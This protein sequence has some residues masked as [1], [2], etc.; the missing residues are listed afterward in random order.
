MNNQILTTCHVSKNASRA[1]ASQQ[2]ATMRC[3]HALRAKCRLWLGLFLLAVMLPDALH[4]DELD[5]LRLAW[6]DILVGVQY[7][8]AD[9]DVKARLSSIAN[10][11]NASW[12]SMNQSADRTNLWSDAASKTISAHLT[13]CYG[14]LRAMA[15]AYA[16]PGCSLYT[17]ASLLAA[18]TSG[19]DW[20][21]S[22]RYNTAIAQYD[23]WWDWEIGVPLHLTDIGVLLYG[24]LTGTQRTQYMAAVNFHTPDPDMTQANL[25]WKARV[26]AVRGCIVRDTT[27][28]A[29]ARDAFSSVFPFV[30]TSDGFYKDGSFIQHTYH[31]YA[32]GYGTSLLANMIPMMTWLANSTWKIT[33]P[34]QTNLVQW[35]YTAF[36][37]LIYRGAMWDCVRGR[38]ISRSGS[39]PQ[40]TGHSVLQNALLLSTIVPEADR[41]RLR[42]M[43]KYW[44]QSDP[45]RSF[46]GT[47]P[48]PL[49]AEAKAL[50]ADTTTL[51]RGELIGHYHFGEMDRVIHLRPGYGFGIAMHS[52]RIANFESINGENMQGWYTGDGMTL[53]YTGDL[54]Q[55]GDNY[56]PTINPYRL[57]GTTVDTRV[58]TPP[59]NPTRAN[60]QNM[61]STTAWTGGATL[62]TRGTA[63]MHLD[64]WDSSLTAKKSWFMFDTQIV[65]LGAGISSTDGRTVE[66]IVE[67]RKLLTPGTNTFIMNGVTMP[68]NLGWSATQTTCTWAH[69]SG[70]VTNA[71][72]GY[73]FPVPATLNVARE[74]RTGS[75]YAI[76][77]GGSTNP[78]TRNYV[79]L[80]Y[81]HK[82]NPSNAT[83][84]YVLLP[85]TTAAEVAAYAAAPS[86]L[87]LTNTANIQGVKETTTGITALNVW[88]AGTYT[89]SGITVNNPCSVLVRQ[90]TSTLEFALSDPT[91]TNTTGWVVELATPATGIVAL[92]PEITVLQTTPT[93]RLSIQAPSAD[94]HSI[95]ATFFLGK[96]IQTTVNPIADTYVENGANSA[97]NYGASTYLVVKNSG[98]NTLTREAYLRFDL[99]PPQ[100]STLL[101]AALQL[102]TVTCNGNDTQ[103]VAR[104]SD[105]A[106]T[107]RGLVWTNKP[108]ADAEL[109]RWTVH[110]N[111]P[112]TVSCPIGAAARAASG[113]VL[114]LRIAALRGAYVAYAS[115]EVPTAS[116]RPQLLLS[117]TRPPPAITLTTPASDSTIHWS[118][119]VLLSATASTA[120]GT[121]TN[122]TFFDGQRMLGSCIQAPFQIVANNL[123]LGAHSITA[124]ATDDAGLVATSMPVTITLSGQPIARSGKAL[125]VMNRAVAIDLYTLSQAYATSVTDLLYT[126]HAPSNG[127]ASLLSDW[128]TASFLPLPN[129]TGQ[130]SF[131][132]AVTDRSTDPRLLFAYD[133]EAG[134][135]PASTIIPDAS[136]H[137]RHGL[138]TRSGIGTSACFAAPAL[139]FRSTSAIRLDEYGDSGA[140]RISCLIAT[141]ELNFSTQSWTFSGWFNRTT[142]TSDDFIFYL[143]D[144]D[145]FGANE[146][147]HLYGA[148][149]TNAVI[150]RHYIGTNLRDI[151]LTLGT[152]SLNAWHHAA[153]TYTCTN[154]ITGKFCAYLDGSLKA[155]AEGFTFH[156]PQ[157]VPLILGGHQNATYAVSRWF[158][159]GLDELALFNT[160]LNAQEIA[161]LAARPV[162]HLAGLCATNRVAV[163]IL[164]PESVPM[165][166]HPVQTNGNTTWDITLSG[167]SDLQYTIEASTNLIDWLHLETLN[168]PVMPYRWQDSDSTRYPMRFYRLRI[169]P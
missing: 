99:T 72:I 156:L 108:L 135:D 150:G 1:V 65:C 167:P 58:R 77:T 112:F 145:G 33:D 66:T 153:L 102:T 42:S 94:G 12:S 166:T 44:A 56:W 78:I 20:M 37:P 2:M 79:S 137:A 88:N 117:Y 131:D 118:N 169:T 15:L 74:A 104:V 96:T 34:A 161:Q 64:S 97:N 45:I 75:W 132:F 125:T 86:V 46:V 126:V 17:N 136:G 124:V 111:V 120:Y 54:N 10:S 68:T 22:N 31:P 122:V 61:R 152:P 59:T 49:L 32:G 81:D 40:G 36:E 57:P 154:G 48:L 138:L 83:Y 80:W 162:A 119:P 98:T 155:T 53:L 87:I 73:Y 128:H 110:S 160:A 62:G 100:G 4:G 157:T 144:G 85:N 25:V 121:I 114:D 148:W 149:G 67:N 14:R 168:A 71:A 95:Q 141:N 26:V 116:T 82:V 9:T 115:R 3:W 139:P 39:S 107:E 127:T 103:T 13:T 5:T 41:Q 93:I 47:T 159:G 151:D 24:Q 123:E 55:Y 35:I 18:T 29:Q 76:N 146:E 52:S 30:T 109:G 105:H 60:G 92:D 43:V 89:L 101:D 133:F 69:L 106:W 84:A 28:I 23:N 7:D 50:M 164:S 63:G 129:M 90:D 113:S 21:N 140:A 16:T 134:F 38:E 130:A 70:N 165:L 51:P 6:R 19:L 11:A 163:R 91:Q 158:N 142:Q 8:T 143:G 147:L 27:K